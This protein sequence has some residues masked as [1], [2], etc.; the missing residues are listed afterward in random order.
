MLQDGRVDVRRAGLGVTL[1]VLLALC[2]GSATVQASPPGPRLA[3]VELKEPERTLLSTVDPLGGARQ[4]LLSVSAWKATQAVYPFSAPA[5]SPDG[6]EI[7]F[8]VGAE[9]T[10]RFRSGLKTRL[11]RISADGGAVRPIAGTVDGVEPVY[12]PAGGSIAFAKEKVDL[13]LNGRGDSR[14]PF[15]STSIWLA[16]PATGKAV[17]L[18]P[19]RD[20]RYEYPASFSP[21]GSRLAISRFVEG[22]S[23][24]ALEIDLQGNPIR[25]L[26]ANAYEPAYSPDGQ[27]IAFLRG[28]VKRVERHFRSGGSLLVTARMTDIFVRSS[29]GSAL[30]R[31]TDTD[32]AVEEA[33]RWD[34]SGQRLAYTEWHP[35]GSASESPLRAEATGFGFGKGVRM[36]NADG[37]CSTPVISEPVSQFVAAVWQPGIGREAGPISCESASL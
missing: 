28:S 2:A 32:S 7:A 8:V 5:W 10:R 4:A 16:Y 3:L 33:P 35:F 20:G 18:T 17:Q 30:W 15:V 36:I 19:W 37:T 27:S 31:L 29:L 34:P 22:K 21:D 6:T 14:D 26:A 23:P 24:T 25:T 11:A 12:S 1:V 13:R 9:E